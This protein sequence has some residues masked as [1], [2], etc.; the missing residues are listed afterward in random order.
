VKKSESKLS[1]IIA[2]ACR[3]PREAAR[4]AGKVSQSI[5]KEILRP[6][7][8]RA[9]IPYKYLTL[10]LLIL[11]Y[12]PWT[13]SLT[14][15]VPPQVEVSLGD[16]LVVTPYCTVN[17]VSEASVTEAILLNTTP[18]S[19]NGDWELDW[20]WWWSEYDSHRYGRSDSDGYHFM[21]SPST[22]S[23]VLL[24]R[25]IQ[26][27][28][29]NFTEVTASVDIEGVSGAAGVYFEVFVDQERAVE[30]V[31]IQSGNIT[32]VTVGAPLTS[33]RQAADS[34]LSRIIFR[35]QIGLDKAAH[36]KL[37]GIVVDAKFTGN[38]SL[39]QLDIKS[40]EN[41]S[42]YENPY[43]KLARYSPKIVLI[44]NND[45]ATAGTYWP[46]RADDQIYLP[47]GTY[48]GATY[49]D[50]SNQDDPDPT[51][52]SIWEPNVNFVVTEDISLQ[53]DVG[54][55]TKRIDFDIAPSVLLRGMNIFF[56]NDYQYG[57]DTTIYGSTVYSQFPSHLYLPRNIDSLS[58]RIYTW[59]ALDPIRS[60]DIYSRGQFTI[61]N[62]LSFGSNNNTKNIVVSVNLPL[63]AIGN[64]LVGLGEG[65]T[66]SLIALLIAGF[67]ISMRRALKSS[68]IRHRLSD[69][70]IAPLL[71][72]SVSIFLP[73]SIQHIP[74]AESGFEGLSWIS[75]YPTPFMVR[76]ADS[77]AMQVLVAVPDWWTATLTST[78]FLFIPL[79]YGYLS[80]S[81]PETNGF[82]K[83]FAF[84]LFL[85]YLAV[86][87]AFNLSV[88]SV[89]T[90]CIGPI[91]TLLAL[92]VWLMR[93]LFRRVRIT[94]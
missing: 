3:L 15:T 18:F 43:M 63:T 14:Y 93:V 21:A 5:S 31:D 40:S 66:F 16:D 92:P 58:F 59:S 78:M 28:I 71:L 89:D 81:S 32:T 61:E 39:V 42:L 1:Y 26:I 41:E 4:K 23:T 38:L 84:V 24:S 45:S 68:K 91:L 7:P 69:S 22:H 46:C 54:F 36:V 83:T 70:R 52:S 6:I 2:R 94:D 90:I 48:E 86:L 88:I 27:P 73:W 49:W 57:D 62:Y 33:A 51:N 11:L 67:I 12:L 82:D 30:E 25:E 37:R 55:V 20:E 80:M 35:L 50:L 72:L 75:W 10:A 9:S 64:L 60:W 65:V 77:T 76:W 8:P 85:P 53:V 79:F 13:I 87:S 47:P 56:S 19:F 74:N 34:W 17:S 44:Q 29:H